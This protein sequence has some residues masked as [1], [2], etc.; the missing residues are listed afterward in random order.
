MR[1]RYLLLNVRN[2]RIFLICLFWLT[3]LLYAIN[4]FYTSKLAPN[5]D[6]KTQCDLDY[7]KYLIK[8]MVNVF[9]LSRLILFNDF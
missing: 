5:T 1:A 7:A 6:Y 9:Y 8:D 4:F 2:K 3:V